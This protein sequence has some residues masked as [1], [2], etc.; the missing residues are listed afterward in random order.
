MKAP[1]ELWFLLLHTP[2][3]LNPTHHEKFSNNM[4]FNF[5]RLSLIKSPLYS[6]VSLA[7]LF[8]LLL[9]LASVF[10]NITLHSVASESRKSPNFRSISS[11]I[12]LLSVKEE[13]P[14]AYIDPLLPPINVTAEER[15]AWFKANLP[16]FKIMR[17]TRLTGQFADRAKE[18]FDER[19]EVRFF[20]TWIS[21]VRS[22]GRREL[23]CIETLFKA[24]PLGC[25]MILSG[26]MDSKQGNWVLKPLTDAGYRVAAVTPD[27]PLLFRNTPAEPWFKELKEGGVDPGEIPLAQN[28]SN[29]IRL[30]VLYR[31]GGVYLDADFIVL[32]KFSG[33]RNSIGAQTVDSE[34][35]HWSRLNNAVLVFDKKHPLL[36]KFIQEFSLTFNGSKW[37]HNGP[38]LVSRVVARV[39]KRPNYNFT[40]LPPM[41]FYPVDWSRIGGFFRRPDNPAT[42]K[43]V[44]KKLL[45]LS[46]DT[47][48]IHLWNKQSSKLGIEEG[49]IIGQIISDRCILCKQLYSA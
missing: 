47:Y 29:L 37:G 5:R 2:L 12:M 24:H 6:T 11:P 13:I 21:P 25:L 44:T 35:G 17:S 10:S 20:M 19:C 26:T 36:Y 4:K 43:W 32:N 49:S 48:G 31:Y 1:L 40:V 38:Y 42:S 34:T 16:K 27:L 28:L 7:A 9:F 15:M 39:A 8:F 23:L 22:F 3:A 33:L 45:Q 41:A 46:G 30:A 14:E 18:F